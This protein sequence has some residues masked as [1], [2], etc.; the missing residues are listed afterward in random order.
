VSESALGVLMSTSEL[1]ALELINTLVYEARVERG[2]EAEFRL[3]SIPSDAVTNKTDEMFDQDYMVELENLGR[4]L[5]AD[6]TSWTSEIPSPFWRSG[7]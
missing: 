5:G 3:T 7:N 6:P 4:T 1:F 2:I